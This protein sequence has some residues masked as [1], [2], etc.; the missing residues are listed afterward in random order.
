MRPGERF[1]LVLIVMLQERSEK[2]ALGKHRS[3]SVLIPRIAKGSHPRQTDD[4]FSKSS[5]LGVA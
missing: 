5:I 1:K 4:T 2:P 3:D